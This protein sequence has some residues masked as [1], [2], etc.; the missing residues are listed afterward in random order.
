MGDSVLL[1]SSK[2]R[3]VSEKERSLDV[4]V[5]GT[6]SSTQASV[7]SLGSTTCATQYVVGASSLSSSSSSSLFVWWKVALNEAQ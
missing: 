7:A 4:L 1:L 3:P 5:A 6:P 2:V